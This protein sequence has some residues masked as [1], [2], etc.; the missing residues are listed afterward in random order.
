MS[1]TGFRPH[2][3]IAWCT[4]ILPKRGFLG[5]LRDPKYKN[6][7]IRLTTVP[8]KYLSDNVEDSVDY[9]VKKVL[10]RE[11]SKICWCSI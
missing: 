5:T 8:L 9:I 7:N 4:Q 11:N 3:Y 10:K 2:I 1:M 6:D